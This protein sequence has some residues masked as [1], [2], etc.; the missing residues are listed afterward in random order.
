M[1]IR[2]VKVFTSIITLAVLLLFSLDPA[3]A[4]AGKKRLGKNTLALVNGRELNLKYFNERFDSMP[5]T[6]RALYEDDKPGFL[7]HLIVEMLIVAEAKRLG[8]EEEP[9]AGEGV[10][11]RNRALIGMLSY[12]VSRNVTVS[13]EEV[14][15]FYTVNEEALG[16]IPYE[17]IKERI[18]EIILLQKKR[19]AID[20]YIQGLRD[21]ADIVTNGKWIAKQEY[22]GPAGLLEKALK[23][24]LPSLVDYGSD[25]CVPCRKMKPILDELS[26]EYSGRANILIIDI[27]KYRQIAAEYGIRAIPTQVLFDESGK[28]VWRHEGFISKEEIVKKLEELGAL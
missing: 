28:E 3:Q 6:Y 13:D 23:S 8:L 4:N 25:S 7:D 19:E 5:E 12:H 9:G 20:R 10:G 26:N 2:G 1:R 11:D 27:Y 18:R 21:G 16:G 24:G 15:E 14:E 22:E 17:R